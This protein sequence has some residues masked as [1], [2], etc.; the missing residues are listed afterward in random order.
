MSMLA[1]FFYL[2]V[3]IILAGLMDLAEPDLVQTTPA[4][5]LMEQTLLHFLFLCDHWVLF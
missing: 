4:S 1:C 5:S 3:S 2:F